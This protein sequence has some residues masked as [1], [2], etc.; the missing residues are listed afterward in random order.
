[1]S[2]D[3]I[4][5]DA[6]AAAAVEATRFAD[7]HALSPTRGAPDAVFTPTPTPSPPL[8]AVAGLADFLAC[9]W[10]AAWAGADVACCLPPVFSVTL[11]A[12]AGTVEAAVWR[13]AGIII[14]HI[15]I[16]LHSQAMIFVRQRQNRRVR[17]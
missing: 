1:M 16:F 14:I 9:R 6:A 8:R 7:P 13:E 15:F 2:D 3:S 4:A 17:F 5:G 10:D 11:L 12:A